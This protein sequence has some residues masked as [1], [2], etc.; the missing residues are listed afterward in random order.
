MTPRKKALDAWVRAL[1]RTASIPKQPFRT[2]PLVVDELAERFGPSPALVTSEATLSYAQLAET[3]RGYA[4]WALDQ[5]VGPEDVVCLLMAN[6]PEYMAIWL[7]VTRVGGVVSLL[8]TSLRGEPLAH[9]IRIVSPKHIIA[10]GDLAEALQDIRTALPSGAEVWVRGA[11]RVS[12]RDLQPGGAPSSDHRAPSIADRALYIYTS[13]TT[14]LPK[15]AVVSHGRLMQWSHWFAGLMDTAPTDRMY[16]CLPLYHSVGGV[17][18][19]GATL[20]GGGTVVL[21]ERFSAT[22]FW[23]DV[24]AERC[25]LFQYIGELCRYL[26]N[27]PPHEL[28]KEHALRLCCGN[29]LR[30]DVWQA[31]KDRFAIPHILEFYAST[32]GNVSLYNCEEEPGSIGRTPA[33]LAHRLPIAIVKFDSEKEMPVRNA[34]G[35]CERAA[36]NEIGEAIGRILDESPASRFEGYAD[37]DASSKKVLRDVFAKGDAWYRTGDLMRRDERGFHYFVDRVGDTFRWKGENVSA[38]EVAAAL[39]ACRAVDEAVVYGVVVP[40][41]DGRAGMAALVVEEGFDLETLREEI[42]LRL[43]SYARP[44]F[45]RI[46]PAVERTGTFRP[47]KKDLTVEAFDPARVRDPLYFDDRAGDAYVPLDAASYRQLE[48]GDLRL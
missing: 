5:G 18:A 48:A 43:P 39:G 19:T 44:V 32:E 34:D 31:F 26:V 16:H 17:I 9:S 13:G 23:R 21:R 7:G 33:F 27:S 10:D 2:L 8:N 24:V 28:E 46:L 15:A 42:A 22:D 14:G 12:F 47:K 35:F 20:L 41:A 36:V 38:A 3:A 6:R 40:H 11:R 37:A 25:T 4:S 30:S 1:E 29:G 45:L